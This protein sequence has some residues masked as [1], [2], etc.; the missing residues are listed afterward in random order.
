MFNNEHPLVRQGSISFEDLASHAWAGTKKH[1]FTRTQVELAFA[2]R[3]LVPPPLTIEAD[4]LHA[5]VLV[6]SRVPLVSMINT[7]GLRKESLPGNIV[8]RQM[9]I[10]GVD[11]R[12]G[13]LRRRSYL[14]PIAQRSRELLQAAGGS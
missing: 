5:L 9:T 11:R 4:T 8:I 3:G 13:L 2:E 10:P 12:I 14:S 6:V 1:E 7:R